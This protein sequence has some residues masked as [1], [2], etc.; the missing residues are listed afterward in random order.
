MVYLH[1][2]RCPIYDHSFLNRSKRLRATYAERVDRFIKSRF[3]VTVNA[4]VSKQSFGER[5]RRARLMRGLTLRQVADKLA[6][7]GCRLSHAALQ[8]YEK[9]LMGPDSTVVRALAQVFELDVGYF[10]R[11]KA[12]TLANIEFRKL[13]QFPEREVNRVREAAADYF[14]QYLQIEE[15]L[16]IPGVALPRADLSRLCPEDV[17]T[18]EAE[19]EQAAGLIRQK[20]KL[21]E[22]ALNNVHEMLEEHGIKVTEVKAEESFNGFSGWADANTPIIVLADW[23]NRDMPRK[24][25][26]ALHELGHLVM[27]LPEGLSHKAKEA[28]CYRFAGA[29]LLPAAALCARVGAKRPDGISLRERIGIKE[30]WGI[31]IAALMR[32]AADLKIITPSQLKSFHFQNSKHRKTEPGVW[33][34]AEKANRYEQLIYRAAAQELITRAKAAEFLKVSL[35]QFDHLFASEAV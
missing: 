10:F 16:A 22:D 9:G 19:A 17:E 29:L 21:G 20:W 8:K 15:I 6:E 34:G 3:F 4:A 13:T 26:T 5:L 7:S 23:L 32:R 33:P 28:L 35:R 31:S 27:A 12:V 11:Q 25:L 18:L 30:D 24:R 1:L 14:E 2:L